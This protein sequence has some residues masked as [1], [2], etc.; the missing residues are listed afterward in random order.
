METSNAD[1]ELVQCAKRGNLDGIRYWLEH[2]ANVHAY[3]DLALFLSAD[4]SDVRTVQYLV[5]HGADI[6]ADGDSILYKISRHCRVPI[7]KFLVEHGVDIHANDDAALRYSAGWGN[8][9]V[10]QYLIDQG[11]DVHALNDEALI[12]SARAGHLSVVQCLVQ[13]GASVRAT[14]SHG[15]CALECSMKQCHY[16]VTRYLQRIAFSDYMRTPHTVYHISWNDGDYT[17]Q[18]S[19]AHYT[20][21][22]S[23]AHKSMG[24]RAAMDVQHMVVEMLVGA[25]VMKYFRTHGFHT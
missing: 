25:S 17:I 23:A 13:H 22:L 7:V 18:V 10:V 5:A 1:D 24:R 12:D 3:D 19:H 6:H 15:Q 21:L 11:A 16:H 9:P 14:T 2:G 4:A 20:A 8:L